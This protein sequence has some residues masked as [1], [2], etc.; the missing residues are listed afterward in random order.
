[1]VLLKKSLVRD[2]KIGESFQ[3]SSISGI[4]DY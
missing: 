4:K 1:M 2:K 3:I